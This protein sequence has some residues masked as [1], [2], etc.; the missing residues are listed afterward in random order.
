M[1]CAR[2]AL[3]PDEPA[4]P[5]LFQ[6]PDLGKAEPSTTDKILG[7]ILGLSALALT[8]L[9][10]AGGWDPPQTLLAVAWT[11][12][13]W[14]M[15]IVVLVPAVFP[16][17]PPA[18]NSKGI[19]ASAWSGLGTRGHQWVPFAELDRVEILEKPRL[20]TLITHEF[21]GSA[22]TIAFVDPERRVPDLIRRHATLA[23]VVVEDV[24]VAQ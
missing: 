7:A 13:A 2:V 21:D 1:D 16:P 20:T 24:P 3:P 22:R 4:D 19:L 14:S 9:T 15:A 18:I 12:I 6:S 10:L 23:G 11:A 17:L 8:A 5:I